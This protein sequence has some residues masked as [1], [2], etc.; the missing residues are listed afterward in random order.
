M[1]NEIT[2]NENHMPREDIQIW[3]DQLAEQT[4]DEFK[5]LVSGI[6]EHF[7]QF[8]TLSTKQRKAVHVTASKLGK[9]APREISDYAS[10]TTETSSR[11][12]LSDLMERT[13]PNRHMFDKPKSPLADMLREIATVIN[14][15]ADKV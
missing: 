14:R 9:Q 3:L 13:M 7:Y 5:D 12:L 4:P 2:I 6:A 11:E 8:G 1:A 10:D 15:Y